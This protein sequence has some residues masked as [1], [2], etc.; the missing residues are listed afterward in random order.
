MAPA[1]RAFIEGVTRE[2]K[3]LEHA[4]NA[5][6]WRAATMGTEAANRAQKE[7][8]GALMRFWANPGRFEAVK[9]LRASGAAS[10]PVEARQLERI[11]LSAA[12]A[13][14]DEETI[15]RL[16]QLEADV[17]AVYYNYRAEVDGRAMTDNQIDDV[18]RESHDSE[19]VKTVWLA[20]KQVGQGVSE[21]V[22]DLARVRNRAAARQGFRDHFQRALLLSEIDEEELFSLF[23]ELE[24]RTAGPFSDYKRELDLARGERFDIPQE[25]L[26]PWHYG[27][28]FFQQSPQVG[29]VDLDSCFKNRDLEALAV[30]TYHGLG[31]PVEDIL[32]RSDLYPREGKNQHAFCIDLDREGDVRTLNNL[33]PT[34]RWAETLLHEVGHAIYDKYIDRD[35]PWL[36]RKPPH[37]SSTEAIAMLMGALTFDG[38]WLAGT[39]GLG[40]D[41]VG[42]LVEEGLRRERGNRLVFTRWCLVM[43]HFERALYADPEADLDATWWELVAR[44]QMMRR[45]ENL[46]SA[47]WAAKYH[48][49]LSPVY[50]QNYE[51]GHLIRAQFEARIREEFGG[52]AGREEA[53]KW[54]INEVFRPGAVRD[55]KGHLER[56]TG[57]PLSPDPFL[58]SISE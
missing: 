58:A 56:A 54:L 37:P 51:L 5:A 17:Q 14:G 13:Q 36:L 40:E 41:E 23:E 22:R 25:D 12:K 1:A 55:W 8:H 32:Q 21:M 43:T 10:E 52:L 48:I 6:Y 49:A 20:S 3:P 45:P 16:T 50:Y 38:E 44:Y 46:A 35:L 19:Q 15:E 27:D 18:L 53:G 26:R 29:A 4:Y 11:Y 2:V 30:R 57:S 9:A 31:I 39:L 42:T 24:A 7:A 47:A 28:R 33:E 34:L